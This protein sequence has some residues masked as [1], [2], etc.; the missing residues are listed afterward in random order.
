M[1][2][3]I[4]RA[5]MNTLDYNPVSRVRPRAHCRRSARKSGFTLIELLVVIAI[6]AILI[7]MLLPAVQKVREAAARSQCANNLKQI[8]IAIHNYHE[9][10]PNAEPPESW[11]E[12]LN[13]YITVDYG[14]VYDRVADVFHK[15]G[16]GF[17][18][19]T[20]GTP[21]EVGV[22]ADPV[23]PGRTGM[24]RYRGN[25]AL[26]DGS[27]RFLHA[28]VHPEAEEGR[29]MMFEEVKR[30]GDA[31]IAE[32]VAKVDGRVRLK[33]PKIDAEQV[34]EVFGAFNANGD[35]VVSLDEIQGYQFDVD[36]TKV[37][38][39]SLLEPLCLTQGNQDW[40]LIP[41]VLLEEVLAGKPAEF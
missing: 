39:D 12:A 31:L 30:A 6:I 38:L 22:V 29:R 2:S 8:G 5:A 16:Y 3:D 28:T 17:G 20:M 7:G 33:I 34:G 13:P 32:L 25:F 23:C 15:G 41:G 18:F 35:D 37:G 10:N 21:E 24:L 1:L 19:V 36:G 26:A 9:D 14:F 4:L 40:S 11:N 27:V